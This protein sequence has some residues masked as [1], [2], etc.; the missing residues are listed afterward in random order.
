MAD[1][2][3]LHFRDSGDGLDVVIVQAM[4]GIDAQPQTVGIASSLLNPR[5]LLELF[6][7]AGRIGIASG[8]DFDI[9][10][11][12]R[13]GC[14]DLGMIRIDE[15]RHLSANLRQAADGR[16]HLGKLTG[17]IQSPFGGHFGP[18][19]R[20]QADE[21]RL[22]TAGDSHHLLGDRHLQVHWG[23]QCLAQN[24]HVPIRDM[25]TILAQV[26]GDAIGAR[27]LG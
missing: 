12:N 4:T 17:D 24:F 6:C 10:S 8:V 22:D 27:L 5:Q 15:Q 11:A 3:L 21:V 13:H 2:Q 26:D 25:T 1:I 23:L 14:I 18:L 20:Y 16:L 7:R 9:G 19:L